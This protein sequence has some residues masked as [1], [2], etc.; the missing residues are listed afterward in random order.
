LRRTG[1]RVVRDADDMGQQPAVRDRHL[2]SARARKLTGPGSVTEFDAAGAACVYA[3]QTLSAPGRPLPDRRP[4]TR[5]PVDRSQQ[6]RC[7]PAIRRVRAV[8]PSRALAARRSTVRDEALE[9]TRPAALPV[10]FIVHGGR[11]RATRTTGC[12]RWNPAGIRRRGL[13]RRVHSTLHGSTGYGQA[14][15]DSISR[16]WGGKPLED[17]QKGLAARNGKFPW[18][19]AAAPARSAAL[20]AAT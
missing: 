4:R 14:F 18:L 10:A 2:G 9:L 13:R 11:S 7:G 6:P 1:T 3:L 16:D 19:D 12:Y 15:T 20:T 17:L 8:Q 5:A